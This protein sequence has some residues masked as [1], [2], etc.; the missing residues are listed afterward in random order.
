MGNLT[1]HYDP[2]GDILTMQT[3]PNYAEQEIEELEDEIL[4]RFSP[5]SGDIE[6]IEILFF[7]SVL[8]KNHLSCRFSRRY[9]LLEVD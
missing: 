8:S 6:T 4:A 3:C 9:G 2:V 7:L 5:T 1:F